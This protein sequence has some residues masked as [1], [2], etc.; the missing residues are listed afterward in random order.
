MLN[1]KLRKINIRVR[2]RERRNNWFRMRLNEGPRIGTQ[3]DLFSGSMAGR[4]EPDLLEVD[5]SRDA[6]DTLPLIDE[7]DVLI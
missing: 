6:L 3:L 5:Q 4:Y 2:D 7:S 1:K